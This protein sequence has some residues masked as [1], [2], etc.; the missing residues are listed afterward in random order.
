[1]TL[2]TFEIVNGLLEECQDHFVYAG[3]MPRR[4]DLNI[5]GI[6]SMFVLYMYGEM[7]G[8]Y[9]FQIGDDYQNVDKYT[10]ILQL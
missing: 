5:N 9:Y 2:T 7:I 1:L 4:D 6:T 8:Q 10:F 3:S